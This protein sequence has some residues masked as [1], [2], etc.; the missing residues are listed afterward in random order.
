MYLGGGA[1]PKVVGADMKQI[2]FK[3]VQGAGET[4]IAAAA[5][6]PPVIVGLSEGLQ[7]ATYSNYGQARRR[8]ADGTM[9]P[10]WRNLCGSLA[11]IV[12]VPA[13]AELWY[14]DRDIAFLREDEKD[15]AESQQTQASSIK[16]LVDAGY[17]ADSVIDAVTAGDLGRLKGKHTGLYSVQLQPAGRA[18]PGR[19]RRVARR[20]GHPAAARTRPRTSSGPATSRAAQARRT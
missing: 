8:F 3:V 4:R 2:D 9:R 17:D 14:D 11:S 5:G 13:D 19:R 12:A 20:G 6:V 15:A 7:A 18:P 10:L 1:T 16:T